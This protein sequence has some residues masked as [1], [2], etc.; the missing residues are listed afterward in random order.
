MSIIFIAF[1]LL[2]AEVLLA[3]F[4]GAA[5]TTRSCPTGHL[6]ATVCR[7]V[8]VAPG[9]GLAADVDQAIIRLVLPYQPLHGVPDHGPTH[10]PSP[11][12]RYPKQLYIAT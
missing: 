9:E 12:K 11:A 5:F 3:T 2:P 10:L 1:I 4:F 6:F 8:R 7:R